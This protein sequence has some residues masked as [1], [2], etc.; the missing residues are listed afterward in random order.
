MN[1]VIYIWLAFANIAAFIIMG[2][3]KLKAKRG[4]WRISEK[5]LFTSALVGGSLGAFA[6]MQIF[7]HKTKHIKFVVGIPSI[8][9]IQ[10]ALIIWLWL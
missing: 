4:S 9:A 1:K 6:G 2:V 3:D 5:A 7:R 10:I 8:M